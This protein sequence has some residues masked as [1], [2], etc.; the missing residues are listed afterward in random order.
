MLQM[1]GIR[2]SFGEVQALDGADFAL[3]ARQIHGL[4]GENGAGKT[5]LMNVLYG[6]YRADSGEILIDGDRVEIGSPRDAIAHG[7]GMV[8]Q[9]FLQVDTYTV[10]ENVVL[11]TPVGRTRGGVDL[12]SA[13]KAVAD[14]STRFGL[15]V[16]PRAVVEDLT[17]GAR[18]RVEILKAL[19]RRV[20]V[21]VLDEPTT[22]LTPQEVDALFGSLRAM[23]A[24]GMSIVFITHKIREVL[25]VC[26]RMTVLRA[27]RTVTQLE[28]A[29]ASEERLARAMIGE[30]QAPAMAG[31]NHA[32]DLYEPPIPS[33]RVDRD[34]SV[35]LTVDNLEV[36]GDEGSVVRRVT[37]TIAAGEVLGVAGVA[38]NGQRE[39]AE[40]LVGVRPASGG[41]V[42]LGERELTGLST[43]QLLRFGVAYIPEDRHLDGVLPTSSVAENLIL[44]HHRDRRYRRGWILGRRRIVAHAERVIQQFRIHTLGASSPAGS[45]SGGNIQRL[46]LARALVEPPRVLVAHNPTRGLDIGS[47]QFVH[48]RLR[49]C[50]AASTATLLLSEDLDELM[51]TSHRIAVMYRGEFVGILGRDDF[52][53]YRIGRLMGGVVTT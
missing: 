10:T 51:T 20:R 15:R 3:G 39:L 36:T 8:H 49:A 52:D 14:L 46:L 25:N 12:R 32:T 9:K 53:R 40:V 22:N 33:S 23:V 27:G 24:E 47:V 6:L 34:G 28:H 48:E 21:L 26:D 11:G 5:T 2:K 37:F 18:Q 16:D 31:A 13:E 19:Y 45:L 29:E 17:V 1:R 30:S 41:S 43:R 35:S 44:G 50:S 4:L 42:H 38:G 7:I